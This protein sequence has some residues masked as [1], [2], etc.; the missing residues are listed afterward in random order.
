[1]KLQILIPQYKETDEVVKPLLDSIALQQN[2]TSSVPSEVWKDIEG[3]EGL[4]KI[5][6]YGH[7][8][9]LPRKGCK[10]GFVVPSLGSSGYLQTHLC[11]NSIV[12]TIM[13]HRLV[14]KHFLANENNY[15]EVNHKD[16]CKTNNCVWNLEYCTRVYNQNYGTAIDRGVKSHN[17]EESA[18]K[19]ALHH[20]Y[21]EVGRKQAKP[22][23]QFSSDGELVR[24][25]E[26]IRE[27]CRERNYSTGNISNAC[28]GKLKNAYGFVWKFEGGVAE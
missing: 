1:M 11:K 18:K 23:L 15:P 7:V 16:E 10:G 3:Y 8:Y 25:W 27:I 6:S 22:V 24:R 12:K 4:Y 2:D 5:S 19:A 9:S 14:A 17:Y 26:S 21:K 28:N 20:N 13:I